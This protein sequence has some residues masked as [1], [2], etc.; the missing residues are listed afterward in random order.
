MFQLDQLIV[1]ETQVFK[2][3][4]TQ[5]PKR[6]RF[7]SSSDTST[8]TG[9]HVKL[10]VLADSN[11]MTM[12]ELTTMKLL[13]AKLALKVE[14]YGVMGYKTCKLLID[15]FIRQQQETLKEL[16]IKMPISK[17]ILCLTIDQLRAAK[18][19]KLAIRFESYAQLIY[20]MY[21]FE[22]FED[23]NGLY[24][25]IN[26]QPALTEL[27]I[28]SPIISQQTI[29]AIHQLKNLQKLKL[30]IER[31]PA[32]IKVP[33]PCRP[34]E[35]LKTL[36]IQNLST[37]QSLDAIIRM[38]ANVEIFG[39]NYFSRECDS[40]AIVLNAQNLLKSL[41]YLKVPSIHENFPAVCIPSLRKFHVRS[42]INMTS[43]RSFLSQN[44]MLQQFEIEQI[45]TRTFDHHIFLVGLPREIINLK[46]FSIGPN[47]F[48]PVMEI[49]ENVLK[50]LKESCPSLTKIEIPDGGN[51]HVEKNIVN[52]SSIQI[53]RFT[54]K[55]LRTIF[56]KSPFTD[57][58]GDLECVKWSDP[59]RD[60]DDV[61]DDDEI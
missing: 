45:W 58:H 37:E 19:E 34:H 5:A 6:M 36:I 11:E 26:S 44:P 32:S 14:K 30:D 41:N 40:T 8:T 2:Q 12:K 61:E 1:N 21:N 27:E 52:D 39:V 23:F 24:E 60:D 15:E 54:R 53:E 50:V 47:M 59:Y 42:V 28:V 38:F 7:N 48:M 51:I 57:L 22:E 29:Y 20:R 46:K 56:E 13:T 49:N 17:K 4:D 9:P 18:L 3:Q 16:V 33:N 31:F 35:N 25:L 10:L 55:N 43:F